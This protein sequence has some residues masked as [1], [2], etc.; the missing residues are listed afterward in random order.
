MTENLHYSIN[1]YLKRLKTSSWIKNE[2]YKFAF[3]NFIFRN[4]K[5]TMSDEEIVEILKQS[6]EIKYTARDRGIQFIKKSPMD[7]HEVITLNDVRI[8]RRIMEESFEAS[9]CT[10]RKVSFTG[11]SAWAGSLLPDKLFPIPMKKFDLTIDYL[12]G[13]ADEKVPKTGKQYIQFCQPYMEKTMKIIDSYPIEDILL[14]EWNKF[15]LE[16]PDLKIPQKEQLSLVDK[17][18][19]A[20]DFH[21][22]VMREILKISPSKKKIKKA[23]PEI[24]QEENMLEVSEGGRRLIQHYKIERNNSI[25]RKKKLLAIKK[26]PNLN[27]FVCNFSF[28]QKYG[29]PGSGFIEAHHLNPLSSSDSARITS[30]D[31]IILVCS[32]CHR[33]LHRNNFSIDPESLRRLL[34]ESGKVALH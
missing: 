30:L 33:M 9:D 14:K 20:Q 7:L 18:W 15:Y 24:Q 13:T 19:L 5:W 1:C 8:F 12:F 28:F 11:L 16:N 21:L 29:E 22:Y 23:L 2:T 25:I 26:N 17:V 3:A 31:E 6:Q 32:N 4:V 27:C 10:G 34:E